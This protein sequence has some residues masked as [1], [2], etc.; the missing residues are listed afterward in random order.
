MRLLRLFNPLQWNFA[1]RTAV[2]LLT[3]A[4]L[5]VVAAGAV[6]W[7][8]YHVAAAEVG[9]TPEQTWILR[10]RMIASALWAAVPL[11]LI[12]FGASVLF[13]HL[14]VQPLRRLQ[15]GMDRIARGDLSTSNIP[16]TSG[17]EVG[18]ITRSYN[19]MAARLVEMVRTMSSTAS[20]LDMAVGRLTASARESRQ[21]TEASTRQIEAVRQ[22]AEEQAE[23]AAIGARAIRELEEAA[24]QVATAAQSQA[25]EVESAAET[26][27]QMAHAIEQVAGGAGVVAAAA[28]RT[29]QAADDGSHAV[30]LSAEGMDQVRRRVLEA[31]EKLRHL[32]DSLSHVD[33]ILQLITEIAG[34]TDLLALNAAIEAARVGEHGKGFAVVAGEVRRL[35]E[36]SRK[37]ATDIAGRIEA[38]RQGAKAVVETMEAGTGDV[39]NGVVLSRKAGEALH[40]ILA[41]AAETQAQVESISAASE[42]ISAASAQV[43]NTTVQLSAIAEENAATAE[44]MLAGAQSV[45]GL[46]AEVEKDSRQNQAATA[47]MAGAAV[48]VG[49]A[50]EQMAQLAARVAEMANALRQQAEQFRT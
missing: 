26:V 49:T 31:A 7:R 25:A 37:A 13:A 15:E 10:D 4:V 36:R 17:D 23:Q 21:A 45:T 39:E 2:T 42:E 30:R 19:T 50:V 8:T 27:R 3:W 28:A 41:A 33:E 43:V 40:R 5:P 9:L 32:S 12:A 48:Q 29:R 16:I 18:E 24:K 47:A 34:Q 46:V 22:T 14:V 11:F 38:L 35:A 6:V 1:P 20:A 44:E